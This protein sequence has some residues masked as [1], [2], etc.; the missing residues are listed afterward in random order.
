MYL[1]GVFISLYIHSPLCLFHYLYICLYFIHSF[2]ISLLQTRSIF[3]IKRTLNDAEWQTAP[4]NMAQT[5]VLLAHIGEVPGS[6]YAVYPDKMTEFF[7]GFAQC[8]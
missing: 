1:F 5:L 2:I 6:K 7:R 8:L 3:K 4:K